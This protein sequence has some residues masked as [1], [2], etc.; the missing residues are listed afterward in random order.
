MVLCALALNVCSILPS[1]AQTRMWVGVDD[2]GRHSCPSIEC[3][4]V[5]RLF[6]RESVLVYQTNDGWARISGYST[7]GCH[8]GKAAFV[9]SGRKDCSKE[10][11]ISNGE[12]AEWVESRK[13]TAVK[14]DRS[15]DLSAK[16]AA[17]APTAQEALDRQTNPH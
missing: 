6:F 1:G 9:Q 4:I 14:P 7:A 5:G 3:G 15:S 11:G 13:L 16:P 8:E 17:T 10:N 12:F 2:L